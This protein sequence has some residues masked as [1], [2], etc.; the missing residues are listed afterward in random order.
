EGFWVILG[1]ASGDSVKCTNRLT[2][3]YKLKFNAS[4][5][6]ECVGFGPLL[7]VLSS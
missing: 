2:E 7:L 6:V 3:V 5:Q 1:C 4:R